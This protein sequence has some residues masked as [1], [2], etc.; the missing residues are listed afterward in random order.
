MIGPRPSTEAFASLR[1]RRIATAILGIA[2]LNLLVFVV[3]DTAIFKSG[4][5]VEREE[6]HQ[7]Y[8]LISKGAFSQVTPGR[9]YLDRAYCYLTVLGHVAGMAAGLYLVLDRADRATRPSRSDGMRGA[10]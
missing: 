7:P 1:R 2:I 3:V 5:R 4:R 8:V 6:R 9:Y 10:L